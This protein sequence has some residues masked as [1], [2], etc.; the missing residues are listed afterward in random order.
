MFATIP[1]FSGSPKNL[2]GICDSEWDVS[3]RRDS[4][5]SLDVRDLV[6]E[7]NVWPED[8]QDLGLLDAAEEEYLVDLNAPFAKARYDTF[9]GRRVP[10]GDNRDADARFM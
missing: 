5:R 9:V 8:L 1:S 2:D 4:C 6:I 10:S 7:E 3:R